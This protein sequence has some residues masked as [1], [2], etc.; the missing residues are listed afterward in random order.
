[1]LGAFAR[2][3]VPPLL[4]PGHRAGL[5]AALLA[6]LLP[7][8]IVNPA[9][10]GDPAEND[11]DALPGAAVP[12]VCAAHPALGAAGEAQRPPAGSRL[13]SGFVMS[14]IPNDP[15][16]KYDAALD[17]SLAVPPGPGP[18]PLLVQVH[19]YGGSKGG[20]GEDHRYLRE[21]VAFLR[22]STRGLGDS[23]GDLQLADE[24]FEIRDIQN[25]V[26]QVV[27]GTTFAPAPPASFDRKR[28]AVAG[29]S[30]G[31]G[32]SLLL[33][34]SNRRSWPCGPDTCEVVT[35]VPVA[36]WTDLVYSL[37]PNGRPSM[38]TDDPG[39][40]LGVEKLTY[41]SLLFGSGLR[42]DPRYG[43]TN[44][45]EFLLRYYAFVTAGEPYQDPQ[46]NQF[47]PYGAATAKEALRA[48]S[49]DRSPAYREYC[50]GGT[51]PIF[52][53]QGW[54]DDLFTAH[55]VIRLRDVLDRQC[56]FEYPL[57]LY[58]G[59][60]GHPRAAPDDPAEQELILGMVRDWLRHYLLDAG[61][62]PAFDVTSG[63]THAPG[64]P[65]DPASVFRVDEVE[66]MMRGRIVGEF[67][68][69]AR[70]THS[71]GVP[72]VADLTADP[73]TAAG[74]TPALG[75][76]RGLGGPL[77][78]AGPLP[79]DAA[80][81]EIPADRIVP[82]G[83]PHRTVCGMGTVRIRGTVAGSDV[84]Y[85]ARLWDAGP[86]GRLLVDRGVFR[87][88]GP[89]GDLDVTIPLHGNV[90]RVRPGHT[91]VLEVTNNDGPYLR[92]SNLPSATVLS[93][94][95]LTLP[96]CE[97]DEGTASEARRAGPAAAAGPGGAVGAGKPPAVGSAVPA[98]A[99]SPS[100]GGLPAIPVAV[101]T[102]TEMRPG[103][104]VLAATAGRAWAP[105]AGLVLL[106]AVAAGLWASAGRRRAG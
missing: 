52:A 44:Y 89:P 8:T 90:W 50:T 70:I 73:I 97:V 75:L 43:L 99:A 104:D 9:R 106:A 35:A 86:G 23:Y 7:A 25:I 10:A 64:E 83:A 65:F 48:L 92:P 67:G 32:Q 31:G 80:A 2:R 100:S 45:P 36:A 96:T 42:A 59:N 15:A 17:T 55:E 84:Q 3:R 61:P 47:V 13:C 39:Y 66:D 77:E 6:A 19:G 27:E 54:T 28:I 37:I 41:V 78:V 22:Y 105:F 76:L 72:T 53:V 12:L 93:G 103:R 58:L 16:G 81:Y 101:E 98:A 63:V 102:Q 11:D 69:E 4:R 68:G 94:V 29:V 30:Y 82:E 74:A 21:G 95:T 38:R 56:G 62:A 49:L 40:V 46:S 26:R 60:S 33:A 1:M 88:L 18:F 71:A 57:K 87:Y 14:R 51:I 85:A 20:P 91:L 79:G 5:A 24:D 34:Q